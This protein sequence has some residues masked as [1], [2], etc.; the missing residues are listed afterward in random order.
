MVQYANRSTVDWLIDEVKNLQVRV[1]RLEVE[2]EKEGTI[3]TGTK[4]K[5]KKTKE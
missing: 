1:A 5:S 4:P 3:K 2:A